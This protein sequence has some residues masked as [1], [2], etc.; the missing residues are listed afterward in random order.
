MKKQRRDRNARAGRYQR[1][2]YFVDTSTI[3]QA[4]RALGVATD[5]EVV[6]LAVRRVLEMERMRRFMEQTEGV[7]KPGSIELP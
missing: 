6:R 3:R 5:A 2:S 7:L 4:R 1:R